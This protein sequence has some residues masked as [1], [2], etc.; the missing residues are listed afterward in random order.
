MNDEGGGIRTLCNKILTMGANRLIEC[1][2]EG[3]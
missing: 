2:N 3:A 1:M